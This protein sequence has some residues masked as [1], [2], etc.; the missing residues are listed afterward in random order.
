M[1]PT[2]SGVRA[3]QRAGNRPNRVVQ[4]PMV[5]QMHNHYTASSRQVNDFVHSEYTVEVKINK[6]HTHTQEDLVCMQV[7]TPGVSQSSARMGANSIPKITRFPSIFCR[8][9]GRSLTAEGR[10]G[11]IRGLDGGKTPVAAIAEPLVVAV[12]CDAEAIAGLQPVGR[13]TRCLYVRG[14]AWTQ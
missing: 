2:S 12:G 14:G 3:S 13:H 10:E 8:N 9:H 4:G 6:V 5:P 7:C 1:Q 11:R